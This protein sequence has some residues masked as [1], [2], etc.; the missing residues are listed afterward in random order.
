[1]IGASH[2]PNESKKSN[3]PKRLFL[4]VNNFGGFDTGQGNRCRRGEYAFLI[5]ALPVTK[6]PRRSCHMDNLL[7]YTRELPPSAAERVFKDG[8]PILTAYD[9][10]LCERD[11]DRGYVYTAVNL[12]TG[13][14]EVLSRNKNSLTT[15]GVAAMVEKIR[16]SKIAGKG[17]LQAERRVGEYICLCQ[18]KNQPHILN[19]PSQKATYRI[20]VLVKRS[21]KIFPRSL[22]ENTLRP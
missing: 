15:S 6:P 21:R 13:K 8:E 16:T 22:R 9:C 4:T 2:N 14:S 5:S 11:T 20:V 17:R 3:K 19:K 10:V 18:P 1:V 12:T 7:E